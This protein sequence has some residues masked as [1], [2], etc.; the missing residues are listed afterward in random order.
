M[1]K[2]LNKNGADYPEHRIKHSENHE[3]TEHFWLEK[4]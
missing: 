1:V 3:Y 2:A 4:L